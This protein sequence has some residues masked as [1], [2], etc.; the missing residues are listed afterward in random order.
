[1]N[2][3]GLV[4]KSYRVRRGW[5]QE[6][7][8]LSAGLANNA[9]FQY[10]AGMRAPTMTTLRKVLVELGVDWQRFGADMQ[11][12]DPLVIHSAF[13]EIEKAFPESAA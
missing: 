1:M 3:L 9:I 11:S 6:H 7:L 5:S 2:P 13:R 12:A 4:L 8:S 10:E